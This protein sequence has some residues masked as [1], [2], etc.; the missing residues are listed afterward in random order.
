FKAIFEGFLAAAVEAR[1]QLSE[2]SQANSSL[3]LPAIESLLL[4]SQQA[5]FRIADLL[6]WISLEKSRD[7]ARKSKERFTAALAA[8]VQTNEDAAEHIQALRKSAEE[9][10]DELEKIP[11]TAANDSLESPKPPV[12]PNQT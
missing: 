11:Q 7:L 4:R 3:A 10:L 2:Y 5:S 1:S 9:T 12:G 8:A 6:H